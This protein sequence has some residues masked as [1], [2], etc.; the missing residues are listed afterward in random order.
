MRPVLSVLALCALASVQALA[1]DELN[2][3]M[4]VTTGGTSGSSSGAPTPADA[5]S[6]ADLPSLPGDAPKVTPQPGDVQL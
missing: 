5:G 4:P 6:D 1:C 2:R 3:P